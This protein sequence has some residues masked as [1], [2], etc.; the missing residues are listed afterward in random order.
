MVSV[1]SRV[2]AHLPPPQHGMRVRMSYEEFLVW[3]PDNMWVEWKDGEAI[4]FMPASI[5]HQRIIRRLLL[6][7]G[8]FVR[9]RGLGEVLTGPFVAKLWPEG[10]AREPDVLYISQERL[11][12]LGDM[13]FAGG[14]DLMVEV[15]SPDS[16]HRDREE[17]RKEY[18]RAGVREYWVIEAREGA[19]LRR[20]VTVYRLDEAGQ[21]GPPQTLRAGILYSMVLP[22]FWLP[23]EWLWQAEEQDA[24]TLLTTILRHPEGPDS[25]DVPEALDGLP[26]VTPILQRGHR[27][28]PCGGAAHQHPVDRHRALWQRTVRP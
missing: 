18:A 16:A 2:P 14:P 15:I 1:P 25:P 21:Y 22:G 4:V 24:Q 27:Q 28:G 11:G 3:A 19:R 8:L 13:V 6:L 7:L 20:S 26:W 10:P 9:A 12:S 23:V 17:K 5:L